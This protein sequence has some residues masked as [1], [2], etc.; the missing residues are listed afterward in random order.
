MALKIVDAQQIVTV[1]HQILIPFLVFPRAPYSAQL[2]GL[3]FKNLA[4][5]S[6]R[7]QIHGY[8]L[9]AR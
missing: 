1:F 2:V 6:T 3:R 9:R 5:L 8:S 4:L 7:V